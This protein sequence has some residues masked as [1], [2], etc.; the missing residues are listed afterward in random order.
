MLLLL[1]PRWVLHFLL[2]QAAT[3]VQEGHADCV[4]TC[5]VPCAAGWH[6]SPRS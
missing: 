3:A 4:C 1:R 6:W 2:W 5:H